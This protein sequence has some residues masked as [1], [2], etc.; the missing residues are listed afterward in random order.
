VNATRLAGDIWLAESVGDKI[1]SLDVLDVGKSAA[2]GQRA[3]DAASFD[4]ASRT[5]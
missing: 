4:A 2:P 5:A 1:G 3:D